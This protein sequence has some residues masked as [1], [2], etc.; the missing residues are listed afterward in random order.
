MEN[1]ILHTILLTYTL[2]TLASSPFRWYGIELAGCE[3]RRHR[4]ELDDVRN[5]H[6]LTKHAP[7]HI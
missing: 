3:D 6:L 4:L 2:P 1:N 7:C 5:P